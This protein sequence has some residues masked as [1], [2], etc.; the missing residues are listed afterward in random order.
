MP[1]TGPPLRLLPQDALS[2]GKVQE[3]FY[4]RIWTLTRPLMASDLVA[5]EKYAPLVRHLGAEEQGSLPPSTHTYR[6]DT[7]SPYAMSHLAECY[8]HPCL[9]PGIRRL[10]WR[11]VMR[12]FSPTGVVGQHSWEDMLVYVG[13]ELRELCINDG[14]WTPPTD[15]T[16]AALAELLDTVGKQ[17]IQELQLGLP[18]RWKPWARPVDGQPLLFSSLTTIE[19]AVASAL[20]Y[21]SFARSVSLPQVKS[22]TLCLTP[23]PSATQLDDLFSA[24]GQQFSPDRLVQLRITSLVPDPSVDVTLRPIVLSSHLRSLLPFRR[25]QQITIDADWECGYDDDDVLGEM[26]EAWPGLQ[27]ML[28]VARG[29]LHARSYARSHSPSRA[30]LRSLIP[31]ATCCKDLKFLGIWLHADIRADHE[32]IEAAIAQASPNRPSPPLE[33]L[34]VMDSTI[35]GPPE[36]I[37]HFLST[38]FPSLPIILANGADEHV[39]RWREVEK[40]LPAARV[41]HR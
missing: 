4:T 39:E 11:V 1:F 24:I 30:T 3:G 2:S 38:L 19:I 15:Y 20:S 7:V 33:I 10:D 32:A 5:V 28:L 31:F 16:L 12:A 9:F 13:P 26:A 29:D 6:R 41:R 35:E 34:K 21:I 37:A 27:R 23:Y 40:L 17:F 8:P 18:D 22:A 36:R 25:M 14:A